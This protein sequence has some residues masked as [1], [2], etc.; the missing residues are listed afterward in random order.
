MPLD[1]LQSL[2]P[3]GADVALERVRQLL[4]ASDE[5]LEVLAPQGALAIETVSWFNPL[6]ERNGPFVQVGLQPSGPDLDGPL[7]YSEQTIAVLIRLRFRYTGNWNA[8]HFGTPIP[9]EFSSTG[10]I[11][12]NAVP[13]PR[14]MAS[15]SDAVFRALRADEKLRFRLDGVELS[16]A[17][18]ATYGPHA[19]GVEPAL[20]SGEPGGWYNAD[21][22]VTYTLMKDFRTGALWNLRG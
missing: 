14:T 1:F 2:P 22:T 17:R 4:V 18:T 10:G 8:A 7:A 19:F 13:V 20:E 15:W 3:G 12:V 21:S 16:A 5:I 11:P 6:D 9:L